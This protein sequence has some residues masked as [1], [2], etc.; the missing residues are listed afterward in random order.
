MTCGV[1]NKPKKAD[2]IFNNRRYWIDECYKH[3]DWTDGEYDRW[4]SY[5]VLNY[6]TDEEETMDGFTDEQE[7]QFIDKLYEVGAKLFPYTYGDW[8]DEI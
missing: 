3:T 5:S 2:F 6:E 4:V 8:A 7:E 1:R